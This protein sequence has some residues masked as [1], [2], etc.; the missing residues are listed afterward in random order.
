MIKNYELAF[1]SY[2]YKLFFWLF[3]LF[4]GLQFVFWQKTHDIKP[5]FELLEAAPSPAS[6]KF[7]ALGDDEFLYRIL[8]TK[9]Q[10]AGDIFAGFVALK[11]YDYERLYDWFMALDRLNYNTNMTPA[12][13]SYIYG[14]TKNP[15]KLRIIIDYLVK[16]GQNDL[17]NNWWWLF[18]GIYHASNV[19]RDD[20]LALEIAYILSEN[21]DE[22]APLWTRQMPAF[23]HA[24]KGDGC[25][26]FG[27]I[28]K[29]ID[30][31][32]AKG[33]KIG[34]EEQNFMRYFINNRLKRLKNNKFDPNDC[35]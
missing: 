22:N 23:I 35:K 2:S 24:K 21:E 17:K 25:A 32:N 4:F 27:I 9:I 20:D 7:Q 11:H 28:K 19:L 10:N 3:M 34:A 29:I 15:Q 26:A 13:A 12:L 5:D 33:T 1:H 31:A 14:S 16:H 8:A 6:L 30:D 18:Q